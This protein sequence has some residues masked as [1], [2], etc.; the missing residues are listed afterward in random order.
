MEHYEAKPFMQATAD[1]KPLVLDYLKAFDARDL[2]RCLSFCNEDATFHFLWRSFRGRKGIEKWH[3]ERFAADLRVTRVDAISVEGNTVTVDVIVASNKLKARKVNQMGG[4][5][6]LRLERG[7]LKDVKF[8]LRKLGKSGAEESTDT[9]LYRAYVG[10]AEN[11]DVASAMQF[12]LL[13]FLGL[14]D[15]HYLLDVGCGSL[16]AGR[17][18]VPYLR[19][20]RYFGMEPEQWLIEEGIKNEIGRDLIDI[21]QPKF[22]ND[23]DFT[24]TVFRQQF[25]FILAQSVFSHTSQTQMR[26]CLSEAKKAMQPSAMFAATYFKGDANYTG[27]EWVY[28]GHSS[29]RPDLMDGLAAEQGLV[30][31]HLDWPHPHG[32]SWVVFATRSGESAVPDLT[33]ICKY[34]NYMGMAPADPTEAA[35]A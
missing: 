17:L 9:S 14:R 23:P 16:R 24:L 1:L 18:F 32:Q 28:P 29:F 5:I 27:E 30:C 8:A 3:R 10:P 15:E 20:G 21:K 7:A 22:S 26:R 13:T 31:K 11:Y 4:R 19:P 2:E 12:N 34:I 6:T 33:G 35:G 25:D